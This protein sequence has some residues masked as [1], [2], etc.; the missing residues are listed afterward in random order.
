MNTRKS[1][2]LKAFLGIVVLGGCLVA[3]SMAAGL[4]WLRAQPTAPDVILYTPAYGSTVRVGEVV[5]VRAVARHARGVARVELWADGELVA[6]QTSQLPEGSTPFPITKG[7]IPQT[8][9]RH[10]LVVRAYDRSRGSG[11]TMTIVEAEE[12]PPP[13]VETSYIVQEGDTLASVADL[14]GFSTADLAAANPGVADPLPVGAALTLPPPVEDEAPPPTPEAPLEPL[15]GETIPD[16]AFVRAPTL[17]ERLFPIRRLASAGDVRIQVELLSLEVSDDFD[18]VYCYYALGD[19]LMERVPAEGY[20]EPA[21]ARKWAIEPWMAGDHRRVFVLPEGSESLTIRGQCLGYRSSMAGGEVFDLGTMVLTSGAAER[22]GS[23]REAMAEGRQGWFRIRY[24]L[25]SWTG[26]DSPPPGPSVAET[27]AGGPVLLSECETRYIDVEW[28]ESLGREVPISRHFAECI[29]WLDPM[30]LPVPVDHLLFL[31]NGGTYT[32]VREMQLDFSGVVLM[33]IVP[34][35]EAN[36][37]AAHAMYYHFGLTEETSG[38]PGPDDVYEFRVMAWRDDGTYSAVSNVVTI[39]GR[40][41]WPRHYARR[42]VRLTVTELDTGC[43]YADRVRCF[44]CGLQTWGIGPGDRDE[45]G[46][47]IITSCEDD[48][49]S[50]G[51]DVTGGLDANGR[52]VFRLSGELHSAMRYYFDIP[53]ITLTLASGEDL[54]LAMELWEYDVASGDDPICDAVHVHSAEELEEIRESGGSYW[55]RGQPFMGEEGGCYLHYRIDVWN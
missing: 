55:Y 17:L 10:T 44:G 23:L 21:G 12:G 30:S 26:Y 53:S 5:E 36:T 29:L 4:L 9:G 40:D 27:K 46:H 51:D 6:V 1:S 45:F 41:L 32:V 34:A 39:N 19:G 42:N 16:P 28:I 48:L 15:P 25:D 37:D 24:A 47:P 20:F 52:P 31:R 14:Y 50:W 3:I 35:L 49:D 8:V 43:L 7:W 22:D 38:L 54:V 13:E 2:L 11:Q 18:G 33:G